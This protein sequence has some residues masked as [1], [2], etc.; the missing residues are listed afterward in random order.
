[1][2][3]KCQLNTV[4]GTELT[5]QWEGRTVKHAVVRLKGAMRMALMLLQHLDE[6]STGQGWDFSV[7]KLFQSKRCLKQNLRNE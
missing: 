4:L 2:F 6:C 3:I 7:P 5:L 1:M